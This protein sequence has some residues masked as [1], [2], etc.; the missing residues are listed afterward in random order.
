MLNTSTVSDTTFLYNML[1]AVHGYHAITLAHFLSIPLSSCI[2]LHTMNKIL[3]FASFLEGLDLHML[4]EYMENISIELCICSM[5]EF[6]IQKSK[7]PPR[8]PAAEQSLEYFYLK[9][10]AVPALF[11]R[12]YGIT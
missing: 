10:S 12:V 8:N 2:Y 7:N 6:P 4:G 3:H 11:L 1:T 5:E 9:N